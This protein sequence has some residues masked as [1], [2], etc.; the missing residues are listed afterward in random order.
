MFINNFDN[1]VEILN[2]TQQDE[3][4]LYGEM[5]SEGELDELFADLDAEIT[6]DD[7]LERDITE[8]DE[9]SEEVAE[10]DGLACWDIS[11]AELDAL[12][13]EF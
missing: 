13:D 7:W 10:F 8:G 9:E 4:D 6:S 3:I 2:A 12:C 1:Q 11:E 5:F